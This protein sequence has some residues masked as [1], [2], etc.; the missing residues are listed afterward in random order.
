MAEA[1]LSELA[2]KSRESTKHSTGASSSGLNRVSENN[3][4][5]VRRDSIQI[6]KKRKGKT[7][8]QD[9]P[10]QR[11]KLATCEAASWR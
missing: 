5:H 6:R 1:I 9:S 2:R 11:K 4:V 7:E 3:R 10:K 8:E